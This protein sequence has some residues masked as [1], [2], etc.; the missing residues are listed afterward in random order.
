M[1]SHLPQEHDQEIRK[2]LGHAKILIER[3][4]SGKVPNGV[5]R[6]NDFLTPT[7]GGGPG[8]IPF[9]STIGELFYFKKIEEA[10]ELG[11]NEGMVP[12]EFTKYIV[13]APEVIRGLLV[14][15]NPDRLG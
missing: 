5:I 13:R 3:I 12:I 4:E 2:Y 10:L 15:D 14:Q 11:L 1:M 9:K 7:I 8:P 6:D